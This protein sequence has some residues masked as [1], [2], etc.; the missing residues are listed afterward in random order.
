MTDILLELRGLGVEVP[1]ADGWHPLLRDIRLSLRE[2]ESVGL[3]GASGAGKSTLAQACMRLLPS[4][5]RFG[6]G[7]AVHWMGSNLTAAPESQW[8]VIRGRGIAL[9]P[10]E[11][12]LALTPVRRVGD[13]LAEA[14]V[15][16]GLADKAE[17][18][19]RVE[20]VLA[21]VGIPAAG[22]AMQ[23]FPHQFSGGQRQRLLIAAALVLEPRLIIADE[24]TTAL[25]P[26]LQA[27]VLDLLEAYRR[28]TGCSLLLISHDLD[29]IGERAAR[30]MVLDAGRLVE[31]APTAV[32]L[33]APGSEAARRLV[34]ARRHADGAAVAEDALA[35]PTRPREASS[36]LPTS[37]QLL[38]AD[39]VIV[40]YRERRATQSRRSVI[41]AVAGVS[42]G[43]ARGE[44]LGL[45]GESGCG[46]SSLARALLRLGPMDEGRVRFGPADLAQ[47]AHEPLRRVRRRLQWIP[48]DAGA[49]L[50]PQRRVHE[51]VA[52]GMEAHGIA[53]GSEAQRRA[54]ELLV[55]LGLPSRAA[56]AIAGTL[57]T[58]E[59]QRV[60]IAR[61]LALEPD[62]LICDEPV[63]SVDAETRNTLLAL[64]AGLRRSRGL[65]LLVISHDL[66]AVR[67]LTDRVAVMYAGRIVEEG[68]TAEV[69]STPRMPYTAALIAAEPTGDPERR[70]AARTL[71]GEVSRDLIAADGCAFFGRCQ[72]AM[73]DAE[74]ATAR[75]SL[76]PVA[77]GH[78]AACAKVARM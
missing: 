69:L 76:D 70:A 37:D 33:R 34:A 75:P 9:V 3:V 41:D 42:L 24:P 48:Q 46:K 38:V 6:A 4:G 36:T 5:G 16:H 68:P 61:A 49:S 21:D 10:Q 31:D 57:S 62:V 64:V 58:G 20:A 14:V 43:L 19:E 29:V 67:R 65:A 59:R 8:R 77:P 13:L 71:R 17:A 11:P 2:D 30:T 12:L 56:T 73:R 40:R 25:D 72:H 18:A 74:C 23:R 22:A 26:T 78:R 28:R 50:T 7:T 55:F 63:A 60:A 1:T 52:E 35:T 39:D 15:A 54:T 45:V 51:L 27:Q 53:S 44:A 66:D 47:L 32:V